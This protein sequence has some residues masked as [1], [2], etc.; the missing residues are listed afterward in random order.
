MQD[1]IVL[2]SKSL[3]QNLIFL[4]HGYGAN[5]DNLLFV[6]QE[7]SK[8]A[9]TAEIH[10]PN[11]VEECEENIGYQWFSLNGDITN[12]EK[13]FVDN[14]PKINAYISSVMKE[15]KIGYKNVIF[16]GFSQGA[17]LSLS[18]GLKYGVHAIIAFSGLLLNREIP[19]SSNVKV[20]MAHGEK[21]DVINISAMI[22]AEKSLKE[23]GIHVKTVVSKNLYHGIDFYVLSRAV[24]F[25][26]SLL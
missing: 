15:K 20:F 9:P 19:T 26:K 10:I 8:A 2:P 6:G 3:A 7:F 18:L 23:L 1:E 17:M 13:A 11:G 24:D 12:W 4:F 5:K 16:S 21:D 22:Q 25:L 14:I